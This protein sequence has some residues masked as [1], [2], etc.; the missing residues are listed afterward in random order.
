M[1]AGPFLILGCGYTGRRVAQRL[2]AQGC[3]VWATSRS[4]VDLPGVHSVRLDSE[5]PA[6]VDTL[7]QQLPDGLTVLHSLPVPHNLA[8]P[9]PRIL[10]VLGNK[11]RR[12]VYL[13]TT[14]VYGAQHEVDEHT[15]AAPLSPSSLLRVNTEKLVLNGPWSGMVLRP[16]AI[17]GPGR[18]AHVSI[19]RGTFHLAGDGMNYVSRIHV[20][21]LAALTGAALFANATGA[22]PVADEEPA[23]SRDLAAFVCALLD[24]PMPQSVSKEQLH[25]TRRA[26]RRVDGRAVCGLL[27]VRLHYPSYRQG[28]PASL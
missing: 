5:D 13:S 12:I 25:E 2:T 9:T 19:P 8:D 22:W 11:P 6:T 17:Y 27:A 28:I 21:D 26:D 14:G 3:D 10:G 1:T 16:A 15:P 23:R 24:C 20:D 7:A 4:G 18:G